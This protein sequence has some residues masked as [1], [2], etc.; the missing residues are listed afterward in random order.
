MS[1]S[2]P[3]LSLELLP[4]VGNLFSAVFVLIVLLESASSLP[5]LAVYKGELN[6]ENP[7]KHWHS[8]L[9]GGLSRSQYLP[10]W[11]AGSCIYSLYTKGYGHEG[12]T[13]IGRPRVEKINFCSHICCGYITDAS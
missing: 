9:F 2:K 8:S 10:A 13:T 5:A 7:Y 1:Y 6:P 3:G 11:L 12:L 4:F